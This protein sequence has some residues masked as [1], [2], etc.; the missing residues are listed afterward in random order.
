MV[1]QFVFGRSASDEVIRAFRIREE[2]GA[3]VTLLTWGATVQSLVIPMENGPVDVALGYDG[4]EGYEAGTA[5]LGTI[6]GRVGNRIG[7]SRFTVDGT[8]Y[9]V[10][11]NERGNC[12][13]GGR[14]G[15]NRKN[16]DAR[17]EG[18]EV[19]FSLVSPDGE[20]GFPGELK[21]EVRYALR[22]HALSISYRADVSKPCPVNLTNHTYFN[23]N[24]HGTGT[25]LE[26][27]MK[28]DADTV[29][30]TDAELIPTG[31]G[32]PVEGT[33]FDFRAGKTVGRD[34]DESYVPI[35]YGKGYDHNFCLNGTGFRKAL[36]LQGDRT[37]L[38][39]EVWTDQPGVQ[40]YCSGAYGEETG[41]AGK[42]YGRFCG[43]AL[44]TQNYP[45]AVNH[46]GFPDSVLRPGE[47]Y[48]T[49]TEYRF[50]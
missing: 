33:P 27:W 2:D 28:V 13:H 38:K 30:E 42:T 22:G 3:S 4:M 6:V 17:T 40:I 15:M 49:K 11:A 48:I 32:I 24:G 10:T 35:G 14:L 25:I 16:W 50:L 18:D 47:E 23:L 21:A 39:M 8:E 46:P 20:E 36:E 9:H 43:L 26:H 45:D 41:K 44:E 29:T 5:Y 12:L 19:I 1:E 37:G 7:G 31:N 34:L